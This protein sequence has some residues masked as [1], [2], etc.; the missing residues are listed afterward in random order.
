MGG[1]RSVELSL[2]TSISS[3]TCVHVV[4]RVCMPKLSSATTSGRSVRSWLLVVPSNVEI[5]RMVLVSHLV[6][7]GLCFS[8]EGSL[9][10]GNVKSSGCVTAKAQRGCSARSVVDLHRSHAAVFLSD[11]VLGSLESRSGAKGLRMLDSLGRWPAIKLLVSNVLRLDRR[12]VLCLLHVHVEEVLLR[13]R[14][15]SHTC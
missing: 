5:G 6:L 9:V 8:V 10:L 4:S 3:V 15:C 12:R 1:L 2:G 7:M 14:S 13:G 11:V